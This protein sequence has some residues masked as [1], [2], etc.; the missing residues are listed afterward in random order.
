[1]I[2]QVLPKGLFLF[3]K[4]YLYYLADEIQQRYKRYF[5]SVQNLRTFNNSFKHSSLAISHKLKV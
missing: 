4:A 5:F 3:L 1:M 2:L